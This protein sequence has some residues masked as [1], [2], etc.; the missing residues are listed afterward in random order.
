MSTKNYLT[1]VQYL[2]VK[3]GATSLFFPGGSWRHL[4]RDGRGAVVWGLAGNHRKDGQ[5]G[6]GESANQGPIL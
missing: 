1:L 4:G 2:W 6:G 5:E 3:R